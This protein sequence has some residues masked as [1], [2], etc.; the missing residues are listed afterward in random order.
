MDSCSKDK[1]ESDA[2]WVFSEYRGSM[3]ENM[4]RWNAEICGSLFVGYVRLCT[5]VEHEEEDGD[6]KDAS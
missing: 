5:R 3:S 6:N 1:I 2:A 4:S